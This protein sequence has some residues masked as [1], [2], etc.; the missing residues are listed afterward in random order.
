MPMRP[1]RKGVPSVIPG[2]IG[3]YAGDFRKQN[4]PLN[5]TAVSKYGY[6]QEFEAYGDVSMNDVQYVTVQSVNVQMIA[7]GIASAFARMIMWKHFKQ[8]YT[9]NDDYLFPWSASGDACP[10]ELQNVHLF[11]RLKYSNGTSTLTQVPVFASPITATTTLG[12]FISRLQAIF[13]GDNTPT[14]FGGD[15]NAWASYQFQYRADNTNSSTVTRCCSPR[16][17]IDNQEVI[18]H[19]TSVIHFQNVTRGSYSG[20]TDPRGSRDAIGANPLIGRCYHLKGIYPDVE[21][22]SNLTQATSTIDFNERLQ[23][24]VNIP[25]Y[26]GIGVPDINPPQEWRSL[27]DPRVFSN[28][29]SCQSGLRLEPGEIKKDVL[30]FRFKGSLNDLFH[31]LSYVGT[32]GNPTSTESQPIRAGEKMGTCKVFAFE[33][34]VP[35]GW[36]AVELAYHVN[37]STVVVMPPSYGV[38]SVRKDYEKYKFDLLQATVPVA[39]RDVQQDVADDVDIDTVDV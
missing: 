1:R 31:G 28:V 16:W 29:M 24:F 18:V 20:P 9:C 15:F 34:V 7:A 39:L 35:T 37:R 36:D 19:V 26:V 32:G 3:H 22:Q 14:S 23:K 6:I 8:T 5:D 17:S 10:P 11:R 12:T 4:V 27:P 13:I 33:K 21:L 30:Q 2:G 38:L 25:H